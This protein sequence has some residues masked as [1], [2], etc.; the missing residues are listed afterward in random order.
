MKAAAQTDL[1]EGLTG[2]PTAQQIEV[3]FTQAQLAL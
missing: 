3:A 1:G 2:R